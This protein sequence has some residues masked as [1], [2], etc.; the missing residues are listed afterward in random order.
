M[1]SRFFVWL[2]LLVTRAWGKR[3]QTAFLKTVF[4]PH[5]VDAADGDVVYELFASR[6]GPKQASALLPSRA[7]NGL[8]DLDKLQHAIDQLQLIMTTYA[9]LPTEERL[10]FFDQHPSSELRRYYPPF[11]QLYGWDTFYAIATHYGRGRDTLGV[12]RLMQEGFDAEDIVWCVSRIGIDRARIC[13]WYLRT[14]FGSTEKLETLIKYFEVAWD[15]VCNE[16]VTHQICD[17]DRS[18]A[19]SVLARDSGDLSGLK[20]EDQFISVLWRKTKTL[21]EAGGYP[22]EIKNVGRHVCLFFCACYFEDT[23]LIEVMHY[24]RDHEP[25]CE[26]L[27][28]IRACDWSSDWTWP[29][30]M[31]VLRHEF[32]PGATQEQLQA[33]LGE[34]DETKR[35]GVE[36]IYDTWIYRADGDL[37]R[38]TFVFRNGKLVEWN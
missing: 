5:E 16:K 19:C 28:I 11:I 18:Y 3:R 37:P 23:D 2:Y 38:R 26:D 4:D 33:S 34:P 32:W 21:V 10:A 36:V 1:L 12:L 8:Y 9:A 14:F 13:L 29:V 17:R 30:A 25:G 20:A 24:L 7:N 27:R 15:K 31:K 22:T 6:I 35:R